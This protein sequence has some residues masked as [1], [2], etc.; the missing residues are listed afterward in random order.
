MEIP[1]LQGS[2][3]SQERETAAVTTVTSSSSIAELAVVKSEK[4]PN[5]FVFD[6]E[7]VRDV[8]AAQSLASL[9]IGDYL[10][11]MRSD[12]DVV[13]L[14]E[15]YLA[16]MLLFNLRTGRCIARIWNQTVKVVKAVTREQFAEACRLDKIYTGARMY[17]QPWDRPTK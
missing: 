10:V 17:D 1:N 8:V 5:E 12:F 13:L 7:V 14:G 11:V 6:L 4:D 2:D 16:S 3:G 9:K 15:P